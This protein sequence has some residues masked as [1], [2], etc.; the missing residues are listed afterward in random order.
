MKLDDAR[1][2]IAEVL[3][4]DPLDFSTHQEIT[5]LVLDLDSGEVHYELLQKLAKTFGTDSINFEHKTCEQGYYG[6]H[7]G[8]GTS[9]RIA[10]ILDAPPPPEAK[11]PVTTYVLCCSFCGKGQREVK[12]LIAGPTVYICNE[13]VKLCQDILD[14][15]K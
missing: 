6:E 4:Q 11:K 7:S 9:L 3:D 1:S 2:K 10:G 15:D 12:K 14:E 13:C 5:D 8:G